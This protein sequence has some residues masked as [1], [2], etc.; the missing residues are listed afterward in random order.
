MLYK[1]RRSATVIAKNYCTCAKIDRSGY[2]EL[3]QIYPSLNE[4]AKEH[5][6][7]YNDPLKV[8]LEISLNRIDFFKDLSKPVKS[9]WIFNMELRQ[10]EPN[11]YLYRMDTNSEEMFVI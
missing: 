5:I 8:F 7:L 2:S 1:C 11:S 4:Y 9:E 3:L 10:L 6:V